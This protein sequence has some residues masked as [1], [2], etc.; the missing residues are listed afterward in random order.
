[1][2]VILRG[3]R[4][5]PLF[6][7]FVLFFFFLTGSVHFLLQGMSGCASITENYLEESFYLCNELQLH[8][9]FFT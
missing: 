2:L 4:A 3:Q 8:I 5:K 7:F 6:L 9:M 1:M